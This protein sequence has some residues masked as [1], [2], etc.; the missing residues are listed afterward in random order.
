MNPN[1]ARRGKQNLRR[2]LIAGVAAVS[3]LAFLFLAANR[4][5]KEPEIR[6]GYVMGTMIEITSYDR[7][8]GPALDAAMERMFQIERQVGRNEDS[9]L[10][11]INSGAS[12]EG[13]RVGED[14]WNILTAAKRYWEL[15]EKTFDVTVG[16]LV[17][18]WGFGYDGEGR[19]PSGAEIDAAMRKTGSDRI[20]FFPEDR[21][22]R[23]R[24]T[25]M[26]LTLGGIAKGYAVEEAAKVL[27]AK[28]VK[29]ALINGGTSSIKALGHGPSGKAWRV[30]IEDPRDSSRMTGIIPLPPGR[31][32]ATSA[33]TRRFFIDSGKRYSHIIDPRTGW[34]AA[35]GIASV[36]VVTRDATEADALTKAIFLHDPQWGLRFAA[37][38]GIDVVIVGDDGKVWTSPGIDLL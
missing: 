33:D 30:G 17:E 8:V 22:V 7:G 25:G 14:T 35:T 6:S 11:R 28:G 32:L 2:I 19:M 34:P 15:S 10:S 5:S 27:V 20:D 18:L 12:P 4:A 29:N 37:S 16:P 31:S 38:N 1:K 9:D 3:G 23:L 24:G 26:A 21:R 36:T 13:L